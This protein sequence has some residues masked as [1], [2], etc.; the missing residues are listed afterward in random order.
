LLT[1]PFRRTSG[2]CAVDL[3]LLVL[4]IALAVAAI[5]AILALRAA[6]GADTSGLWRNG[7]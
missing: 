6:D 4:A 7:D 1:S 2:L 5:A 3:S